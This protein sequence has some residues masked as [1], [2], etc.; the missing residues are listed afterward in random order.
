MKR[1]IMFGLL[2]LAG[3]AIAA[4]VGAVSEGG[5][6]GF[7]N[8]DGEGMELGNNNENETQEPEP[9]LYGNEAGNSDDKPGEQEREREQ[10]HMEEGIAA[11]VH[12][13]IQE[14]KG[15]T[16][17]VPQGQMVRIVAQNREIYAGNETIPLN[18][19]LRVRLMIQEREHVLAFNSSEDD[20]VEIEENGIKVMTRE[21]LRLTNQ[22]MFAGDNE[23]EV[24]VMP[25]QLKNRTR[26]KNLERI[27]LHVENKTPYYELNGTKAGKLF[28]LFDV[29]LP[30]QARVH[31]Q[32]G[33]L[34]EE[35]GP[36][37]SFLVGT[38]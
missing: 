1:M 29:E 14:R 37:W 31:A 15:G 5:A 35:H 30:I 4:N 19:T 34:E 25:A 18:A 16:L 32:T 36:W 20:G 10:E 17:D 12:A 38:E 3:M 27:Q 21:T 33:V 11:Q 7:E 23:T 9:A 8:E 28:G 26:L 6:V 13:I 24:T 2:L 22:E